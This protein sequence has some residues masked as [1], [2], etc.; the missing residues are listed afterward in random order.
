MEDQVGHVQQA[1]VIRAH[2]R[3]GH[4]PC[5]IREG[6]EDH[7]ADTDRERTRRVVVH[8]E[9]SFYGAAEYNPVVTKRRIDVVWDGAPD[10]EMRQAAERAVQKGAISVGYLGSVRLRMLPDGRIQVVDALFS[11][12]SDPWRGNFSEPQSARRWLIASLGP[13]RVFDA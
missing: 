6:G 5:P 9:G 8:G 3:G 10:S 13:E 12:F 7:G 1:H 2:R 11:A 4:P